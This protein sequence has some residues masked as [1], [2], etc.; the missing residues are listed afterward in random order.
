MPHITAYLVFIIPFLGT[1]YSS[2]VDKLGYALVTNVAIAVSY[3]N[4]GLF[5]KIS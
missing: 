1:K 5:C 4:K 2:V 3:D